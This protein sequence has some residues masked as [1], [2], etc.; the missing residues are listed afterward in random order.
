MTTYL[1]TKR[2]PDLFKGAIMYAPAIKCI[3]KGISIE[4][5]S[6]HVV[7]AATHCFD[8]NLL[9]CL[10]KKDNKKEPEKKLAKTG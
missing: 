7:I 2:N 10:I 8:S 5:A 4:K 6:L 1:L 9:D 3:H